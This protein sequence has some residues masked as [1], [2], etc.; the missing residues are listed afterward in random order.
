MVPTP[1]S[2]VARVFAAALLASASFGVLA[3]PVAADSLSDKQARAKQL[4]QQIETNAERAEHLAETYNQAQVDLDKVGRDLEETRVKTEQT[5]R[6]AAGIL[7][8]LRTQARNAYVEG[9][10]S[11][12]KLVPEPGKDPLVASQ[13]V[14]VMTGRQANSLD[15]ARA[16]LA[17]V[18]DQREKLLTAQKRAKTAQENADRLNR[19]AK[20]AD[21]TARASLAEVKNDIA[22]LV[23]TER[24]RLAKE[25][26]EREA[27]KAKETTTAEAATATTRNEPVRNQQSA[28]PLTTP[29]TP[30]A[31]GGR[32]PRPPTTS[33][34][35][36][37]PPNPSPGPASGAGAAVA[38]AR[39]QLGKPY[40][41][42]AAGPNSYDC[43]GLTMSAWRAGGKSIPRTTTTQYAASQGVSNPMPGDLAFAHMNHV[44]LYIGGGQM[45]HAPQ[46]GDVVKVAPARAGAGYR[47]P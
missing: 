27:A 9:P 39:G 24:D 31:P 21:A 15:A 7:G 44:G 19:E 35:K 37:A 40:V 18:K 28:R 5:E 8:A 3:Q 25:R 43:S 38:F 17:K 13:Y 4:A 26:D 47:R 46:T 34:N 30:S 16:A 32:E 6:E 11:G 20:A 12:P 41:Y 45:I 1:K 2:R 33:G 23:A 29:K 36:P 14:Q 22:D 42:G 10:T